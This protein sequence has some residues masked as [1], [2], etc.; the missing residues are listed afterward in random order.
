MKKLIVVVMALVFAAAFMPA[1]YAAESAQLGL[2]VT[3][4][5]DQDL[6]EV[7]LIKEHISEMANNSAAIFREV[8]VDRNNDGKI[9][10]KD[11]DLNGDGGVND[12]DISILRSKIDEIIMEN[13]KIYNDRTALNEILQR[14]PDLKDQ[15][16]AILAH[17]EEAQAT[18]SDYITKLKALEAEDQDLKR[19]E[20][21]KVHI[22]N[23]YAEIQK[24]CRAFDITCDGQFNL[25]DIK[26]WLESGNGDYNRDG[27]VD[28][29]DVQFLHY[30][31]ESIEGAKTR[32]A[33]ADIKELKVILER[34]PDLAE[35]INPVVSHAEE[36]CA[37]MENYLSLLSKLNQPV[38]S[39]EL[40]NPSW[41][42]QGVKLGDKIGNIGADGTPIHRITNTGNVPVIVDIGYGPMP[43]TDVN[44]DGVVDNADCIGFIRPGLQPGRDTFM[45]EVVTGTTAGQ[46]LWA[47]I[48]PNGRV[49]VV[50]I[51]PSKAQPLALAYCSPTQLSYNARGMH[52]TYELRAYSAICKEDL[53]GNGQLDPGEDLNGNGVL[54]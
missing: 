34:R 26:Y 30:A 22:D 9:D 1:A 18:I 36:L 5:V 52:A 10:K 41:V 44:G 46:N 42:L 50:G 3:F 38:I 19:V 15:I 43:L 51:G 39:I 54:D 31:I 7:L 12:E 33:E 37:E 20:E 25:E 47:A 14:R 4:A 53:N 2:Q 11:L 35:Q 48:P 29:A 8:Y 45:T 16:V 49:R 28:S 32:L 13:T 21:I 24:I 17:A 23:N 27:V 6:E 40:S